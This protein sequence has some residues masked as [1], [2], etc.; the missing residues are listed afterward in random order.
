MKTGR[1]DNTVRLR[2][3][4]AA[5]F[6]LLYIYQAGF[7]TFDPEVHRGLY[8][9]FT[10]LLVFLFY[11]LPRG[12]RWRLGL[13]AD[14]LFVILAIASIGYFIVEYPRFAEDAGL[15][16]GPWDKA[17]GLV[18]LA[19]ALEACRRTLGWILPALAVFFFLYLFWGPYFPA[20][21]AHRGYSLDRVIGL[22]YASTEGIFGVVTYVF[23]TYV[24]PFMIFGAFLRETGA[25]DF[26]LDLSQATVGTLRGGPAKAA[27]ISSFILGSLI[28]SS[29]ANT[30]IT[31]TVTI[32]LMK[33]SG[34]RPHV[35]GGI[36]AA[37][38]IGG[39]FMPPV[40]GAGAF[41]MV[42]LTGTPYLEVIK[43]S[44]IPAVLFFFSVFVLVHFEACKEGLEPLSRE[45]MPALG[46]T[47]RNGWLFLTPIGVLIFFLVRGASPSRAAFYTLVTMALPALAYGRNRAP[48]LF[49]NALT[50]G[51]Q[52]S[53]FIGA[54][55]A[56]V[57]IIV[58]AIV[59]PGMGL[60][61]SYLVMQLSH[62]YLPLAI[63]LI[64][65]ASYFLGMG[66]TVVSSYLVLVTLAGPALIDLQVPLITA[67]LLVFWYSQNATITP[68]V[69]PSSYV[70][71]AL[72]E[73]DLWKTALYSLKMGLGLYYIPILFVYTPLLFTDTLLRTAWT[74][75]A[76][77]LGIV[78]L[79]ATLQG[80]LVQRLKIGAR[81]TLGV[82]A[83]ALSWPT[84]WLNVLGAGVLVA[85][86]FQQRR[87]T[88][89]KSCSL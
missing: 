49:L 46:A 75:G 39:Q 65:A 36:E 70:A 44:A 63:V 12:S 80:F 8:I 59:L 29:T 33:R 73:A 7:G 13:L 78:A 23:A 74:A 43:I 9:L 22:M 21:I 72:A 82:V 28:G 77:A 89:A 30:A 42:G 85:M 71:A 45:E 41:L 18:A 24:F 26:F 83:L 79:S 17:L 32:P 10:L 4:V 88:R 25:V 50:R 38:S 62:G 3:G 84:P 34:F 20:V 35:A 68:P 64:A 11:P 19:M 61:F 1:R 58:A 67:H 15:D 48:R 69:C 87:Q 86:A 14:S 54:T 66:L 16:L 37:A 81:V 53:L 60:K 52:D 57:G 55:A 27:V 76:I 31:G 6:S 5:L 51:S 56:V 2:E 47:L 40:M